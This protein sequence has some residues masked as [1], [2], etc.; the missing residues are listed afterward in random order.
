[1]LDWVYLGVGFGLVS[2]EVRKVALRLLL[3][4]AGPIVFLGLLEGVLYLTGAFEPLS[5]V[6]QVRHK[7]KM[8]WTSEPQYARFALQREKGAAAVA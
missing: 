4:L 6:R 8:F 5:V 7:G 2:A 1:V 3:I